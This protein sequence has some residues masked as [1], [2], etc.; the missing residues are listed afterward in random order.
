M[1][2]EMK[3]RKPYELTHQEMADCLDV[4]GFETV[5][6]AEKA[7]QKKLVEW[8]K[9]ECMLDHF[10]DNFITG[11]CHPTCKSCQLLKDFKL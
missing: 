11:E 3:M 1:I 2:K 8:L 10:V 5:L 9:S 4:N 7:A 6:N